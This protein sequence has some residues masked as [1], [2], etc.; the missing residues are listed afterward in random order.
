MREFCDRL[1]QPSK[2]IRWVRVHSGVVGL[3]K[4][5]VCVRDQRPKSLATSVI[6]TEMRMHV[7][8]GT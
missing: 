2:H 7:T 4:N 5:G 6:S 3:P 1:E 8:I